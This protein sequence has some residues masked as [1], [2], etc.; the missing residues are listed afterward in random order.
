M[1]CEFCLL[2]FHAV[3]ESILGYKTSRH[4]ALLDS[5]GRE[6]GI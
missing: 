2:N 1:G 5:P 3:P 4:R 6:G